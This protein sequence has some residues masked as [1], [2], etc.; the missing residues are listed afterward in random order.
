MICP[1]AVE[2]DKIDNKSLDM[3]EVTQ[4]KCICNG[5]ADDF[6]GCS[7][8]LRGVEYDGVLERN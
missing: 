8:Y 3:C 1:H 5:G 2:V 4:D 7:V 6:K